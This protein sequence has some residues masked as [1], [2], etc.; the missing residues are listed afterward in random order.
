MNKY[1]LFFLPALLLSLSQCESTQNKSSTGGTQ[2]VVANPLLGG[3]DSQVEWGKHIVTISGCNDCHTPKKM[4]D[5]GPIIDTSLTLSGHP[6]MMPKID[7]DKK[8][9]QSKGLTVTA[10]LTEWV[11]PWGT[12]YAANLTPDPSGTGNWTEANFILALREGKFKGL[13]NGRALLPPMPWEMFR[14]MTDYELKAIFAYLKTIKPVNNVVPAPLPPVEMTE[15][16]APAKTTK[17]K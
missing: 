11:G 16:A 2:V 17:K 8:M 15:T 10:D 9:I 14:H 1:I 13:P 7:I 4:T 6:A 5:R 3:Y 12:S